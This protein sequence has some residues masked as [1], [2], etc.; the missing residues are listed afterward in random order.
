MLNI[1][2]NILKIKYIYFNIFQNK[3]YLKKQYISQ[4]DHLVWPCQWPGGAGEIKGSHQKSKI[5]QVNK[6]GM[7]VDGQKKEGAVINVTRKC[8][9][10]CCCYLIIIQE[11]MRIRTRKFAYIPIITFRHFASI[12]FCCIEH[13]PNSAEINAIC[14][15]ST[16]N[17]SS[18][19]TLLVQ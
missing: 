11:F 10:S 1:K 12:L 13:Q 14:T 9:W 4:F 2:Y 6:C 16:F 3:N 18:D 15:S 8:L 17:H 5:Y 19:N 7:P